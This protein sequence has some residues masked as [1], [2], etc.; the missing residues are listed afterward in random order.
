MQPPKLS[1]IIAVYKNIEALD[2]IF[3]SLEKQSFKDFEVI[4]AEDNDGDDMRNFIQNA[5][6]QYNFNIK[7]VAQADLGFRKCKA[8]NSSIRA[9][10]AEYIVFIDGDC[11]LHPHFLKAH[12][13][14]K[15][16]KTALWGRRVMLSAVLSEKMKPN[17]EGV[18]KKLNFPNLWFHRCKRLDA[19][20]Y[21]PFLPSKRGVKTA[22]W[23]CNW[24]IHKTDLVAV[25]GFDEDYEQ[26]GI[27]ED[28]DIEWRL[29]KNGIVLKKIK[30]KAIQYHLHHAENYASTNSMESMLKKKKGENLIFIKNG[31][32]K[33]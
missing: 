2:L 32:Q 6:K 28:T 18:L 19:A 26:P 12:F 29:L 13:D 9:S 22:I 21:L 17:T 16:S 3:K 14:N 11:I 7:H 30:N 33:V 15:E 25:N 31:L 10:A 1:L 4:I 5:Q 8:L 27:G 20:L 24:S 23:G